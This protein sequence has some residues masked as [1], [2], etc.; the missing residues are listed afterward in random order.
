MKK[1]IEA[2]AWL[3]IILGVSALI[4]P[5]KAQGSLFWEEIGPSNVGNHVRAMAVDDNGIVWAGAVGGGLWKSTNSGVTWSH[6]PG[7]D[8]NLAVSSIAVS[9]SN[10]YVGTGET[11]FYE[12]DENKIP[13][14]HEDSIT[15]VRPGFHQ[16][17][18]LPGE[19]VF[20][21]NDNGNSWSHNNGSWNSGSTRYN[22]PFMSIQKI[23]AANGRI[24]V[25]TLEGL[26]WTTDANLASL[27]KATG[28]AHF[29]TQPITDVEVAANG[30][31]YAATAD[32]L[33][34][35]ADNGASFGA[36]INSLLPV[37]PIPNNRIGGDRIEIAVAPSDLNTIYVTGASNLNGSCTGVWQSRDNGATWI[38]IAPYETATFRPLQQ[39]GRYAIAMV[40][41]PNDP[42]S[43]LLG[44]E[45]LYT[46]DPQ[47]GWDDA[48]SHSYTPGLTN[49]YVPTPILTIALDPATTGKWYIGT[50]HE[51]VRTTDSGDNYTFKTKGLNN[52]HLYAISP[53]PNWKVL[54][55]DRFRGLLYKDNA[56]S[57]T[58]LQQFNDI[59]SNTGT[60]IG[61]FST[62]NPEF[63]VT[64][65]NDG[66]LR[67][68]QT[69]GATF[70]NF[71]GFPLMPIH[72]SFGANAIDLFI[73][74]RDST[75]EGGGLWDADGAPISPWVIDE[76]I[77]DVSDDTTIQT[78]PSYIFFCSRNYVWVC[79]NPFGKLN[80]PAWWNR[81]TPDLIDDQPTPDKL[82]YFT[83]IA[84]S[85]D[86]DHV[87][88]VGTNTGKL[89]R[90]VDAHDP[91]NM[92]LNT[93]VIR[94]DSGQGMPANR[95]ISDIAFDEAD[96]DNL[97]VTYASYENSDDRLYITNNAKAGMPT[98]RSAQGNLQANLPVYS[99]AFHPDPNRRILLI[100]TEEG[101]YS[102]TSD[103]EDAQ[104]SFIWTRDNANMGNV[105]VYDLNFRK[106]YINWIDNDNYKYSPDYTLFAA[107]YGRG[108]FKSSSLV[109]RPDPR[110]EVAGIELTLSPN[111]AAANPNVLL[112]LQQPTA[113]TIRAYDLQGRL[114]QTLTEGT[115][116]AGHHSLPFDTRDLPA[117]VYI[118]K[119]EL[120]NSKGRFEQSLRAA[121]T[122]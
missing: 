104:A 101:V 10:I 114:L 7:V 31:V 76:Y 50:D 22:D 30:V 79:T 117:G 118:L 110:P 99:A 26:Y 58:A 25:A 78:T 105:A 15:T 21:S 70:E 115:L 68:S 66:G 112:E 9:G 62:T 11:F 80:S 24:Y 17:F 59:Y 60:G 6:V 65:T 1:L 3:V 116:P 40:V 37:G 122:R 33:Y 4:G 109:D 97:I 83:A 51:I 89:F 119:A 38:S 113:T 52:A 27:T 34:R 84:V 61:R 45:K 19:G 86:A 71:Y 42:E 49:N 72:P 55:S 29:G 46:Y 107:T 8:D 35:S 63:I 5:L 44:G 102:T 57:N 67:R 56:T 106:Y 14:W 88:Y 98:F 82:E 39:N 93:K 108:A 43:L 94:V 90:I 75:E 23:T 92:D 77:P 20:V 81:I 69:N 18:G 91:L 111:P 73:D 95:W 2:T 13:V 36:A 53:A 12:P 64:Q 74:R 120:S 100:G 85:G 48:A 103:Y 16:V 47:T 96:A 87:V 54:A 41:M 121:I 32:S 28:T